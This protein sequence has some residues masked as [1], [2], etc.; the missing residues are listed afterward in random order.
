[1]D[2]STRIVLIPAA[3]AA[4]ASAAGAQVRPFYL[5]GNDDEYWG[6]PVAQT[7]QVS[8]NPVG[9]TPGPHQGLDGSAT[10]AA[11]VQGWIDGSIPNHGVAIIPPGPSFFANF[12]I[13]PE[14]SGFA[15]TTTTSGPTALSF[16]QGG[17]TERT[18]GISKTNDWDLGGDATIDPFANGRNLSGEFLYTMGNGAGPRVLLMKVS[19]PAIA[20]LAGQTVTN[21]DFRL[22][23]FFGENVPFGVFP[24]TK[25]FRGITDGAATD[26]LAFDISYSD[27]V[28]PNRFVGIGGGD[29]TDPF[30]WQNAEV[31]NSP[32][33]VST[34]SGSGGVVTI[35]GGEAVVTTSMIVLGGSS[36]TIDGPGSIVLQSLSGI[37]AIISRDADHTI[38]ADVAL[39]GTT[40]VAVGSG[41]TLNLGAVTGTAGSRL[42]VRQ[43]LFNPAGPFNDFG[44]MV[45]RSV[46]GPALVSP[47]FTIL[48][49]DGSDADASVVSELN[50]GKLDIL[51]NKVVVDY[52]GDNPIDSLVN[53]I[54]EGWDFG[55]WNGPG[56]ISFGLDTAPT[57]F[58]GIADAGAAGI[59]SYAGVALDS[60]AV[61]IRRTLIGDANLDGAVEFADLLAVA[62]N[63]ETGGG[64]YWYQGNFSY[65][66]DDQVTFDD[67]LALAQAYGTSLLSD[68]SVAI[69]PDLVGNF[70]SHW[71]LA[72]SVIPEPASL[73]LLGLVSVALLRRR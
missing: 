6:I 25:A 23:G 72:R 26:S 27:Y 3:V 16:Q 73:G 52:S 31:P 4:I 43:D 50:V 59:T 9:W 46:R 63:Y 15:V 41:T 58:M 60:T 39:T 36:Y 13:V 45:V 70:D 10:L 18:L 30:N 44:T 55:S 28:T 64:K 38:N 7:Q 47:N 22:S 40:Q 35:P 42:E 12:Q 62:Q 53:K 51:T 61:I 29:Y 2:R 57:Q 20:A 21:V 34:F 66:T 68:G 54:L 37:T 1:M 48:D 65:A 8:G 14:T 19:D 67:L 56:I 5:A 69:N 24:L 32:L 49:G 33:A 17:S 11:L 71:A